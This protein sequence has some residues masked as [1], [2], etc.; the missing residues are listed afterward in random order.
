MSRDGFCH[1]YIYLQDASTLIGPS[2][3]SRSRPLFFPTV[4][5]TQANGHGKTISVCVSVLCVKWGAIKK[6]FIIPT[7]SHTERRT[8]KLV[9][10]VC[11]AYYTI[12]LKTGKHVV[13]AP[14]PSS[15]VLSC[16]RPWPGRHTRKWAS[17]RRHIAR[18][19]WCSTRHCQV[20]QRRSFRCGTCR[21]VCV[22]VWTVWS[23][24]AP[25]VARRF[26]VFES[27]P[28]KWTCP[29]FLEGVMIITRR[30]NC[31]AS[32]THSIPWWPCR[33]CW[34][35]L[36]INTSI[37]Y[38][39]F[40]PNFL[41][42]IFKSELKK[43]PNETFRNFL[44]TQTYSIQVQSERCIDETSV[45][46]PPSNYMLLYVHWFLII[47]LFKTLSI[48]F[49]SASLACLLIVYS[50]LP[51]VSLILCGVYVQNSR[52]DYRFAHRR[53]SECCGFL[54]KSLVLC[55]FVQNTQPAH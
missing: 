42:G 17:T 33:L 23:P 45:N 7:P 9:Y 51:K 2:E 32:S 55:V 53:F 34:N 52:L 15:S 30:A 41:L 13:I 37:C 20:F 48:R 50:F 1:L 19:V 3:H 5:D 49:T 14:H 4:V 12:S 39:C 28:N 25:R 46:T 36:F 6:I 24:L 18:E 22:C 26:L 54:L 29:T 35:I 27:R 8:K 10:F 40:T 44:I 43:R 16:R 21:R 47:K 38:K 31:S 11:V